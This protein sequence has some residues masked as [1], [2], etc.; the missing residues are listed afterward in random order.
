MH[1][2]T[3]KTKADYCSSKLA[4]VASVRDV[5]CNHGHVCTHF[6]D[7]LTKLIM[8]S[9][10]IRGTCRNCLNVATPLT[11]A[12][13]NG[14]ICHCAFACQNGS[15]CHC[16]FACQNGSLCHCTFACQNGSLCQCT[17][18]CLYSLRICQC[19]IACQNGSI[20][21][22]TVACQNGSL[23]VWRSLTSSL[24]RCAFVCQSG[25]ICS[26]PLCFC[27]CYSQWHSEPYWH[28]TVHWHS[29]PF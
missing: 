24:C 3:K 15:L 20:R 18:A 25:S 9:I 16:A 23:L 28:A 7:T 14:S 22:C 5:G 29:E 2:G 13:Q 27:F 11:V 19:T 17:V 6:R 26:M 10:F 8:L 4:Q 12:C 1:F 21:Q